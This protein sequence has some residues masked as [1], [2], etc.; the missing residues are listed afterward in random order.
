MST[1]FKMKSSPAKFWPW[2]KRKVTRNPDC[3]TCRSGEKNI[4][5]SYS[6]GNIKKHKTIKYGEYGQRLSVDVTKYT[7][8]GDVK[9]T[10]SKTY[11]Q[12][13]WQ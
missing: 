9:S 6:S 4:K 7:K 1:P 13:R 11:N 10:K 2:G 12:K 5:V 8:S 3:P